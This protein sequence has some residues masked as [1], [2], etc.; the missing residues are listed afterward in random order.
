MDLSIYDSTDI[1]DILSIIDIDGRRR[2]K[3]PNKVLG[4]L[5]KG[6]RCSRQIEMVT[7]AIHIVARKYAELGIQVTFEEVDNDRV[8]HRLKWTVTEYIDTILGSDIHIIPT[9]FHQAMVWIAGD[10]WTIP[11]INKELD[12]LYYHLGV[13]MGKF[14]HCPVWRQDK[15]Q[16]YQYM[17]GFMAPTM[18][19]KLTHAE[20]SMEDL[21]RIERLELF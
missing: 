18:H 20:V 1:K 6:G 7:K 4:F 3:D 19:L 9:H 15:W 13:P 11:N 12:R 8:K 2:N 10:S 14:V 17:A 5:S 21:A 16:I